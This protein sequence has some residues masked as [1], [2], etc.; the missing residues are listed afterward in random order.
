MKIYLPKTQKGFTLVELLVVIAI[1]AI[2]AVVGVTIFS[3]TQKNA[4]DARR[5]AD[6]DAIAAALESSKGTAANYPN[7]G[8]TMFA[9]GAIPDDTGN[10]TAEYCAAASVTLP[11][12]WANTAACA[13]APLSTFTTVAA[14]NPA[15]GAA[16]TV[17][18]RLEESTADT[19]AG[20]KV[21]CK[22]NAQ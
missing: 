16:W 21:H 7:L 1:I 6:I 12:T 5:R 15:A 22:S 3:G 9:S 14:N 11:T 8:T 18:A 17:C 20:L 10:A 2:L 13:S 4:R 19:G